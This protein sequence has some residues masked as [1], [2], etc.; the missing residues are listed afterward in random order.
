MANFTFDEA[1]LL[2]LGGQLA[3]A[4]QEY[5]A[6]EGRRA[7]GAG[8]AEWLARRRPAEVAQILRLFFS[9]LDEAVAPL[10]LQVRPDDPDELRAD[11]RLNERQVEAV[12]FMRQYK[13]ITSQDLRAMYPALTPETLRLDMAGLVDKGL[14]IKFSDKRGA[15]YMLRKEC[16]Q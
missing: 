1:A 12:R 11:A 16:A 14:V 4:G 5:T 3:R 8:F 6:A 15:F 9:A 2:R 13:R 10:N 7:N